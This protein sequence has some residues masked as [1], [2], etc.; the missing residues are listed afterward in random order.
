MYYHRADR[1][2]FLGYLVEKFPACFFEDPAQRRP[3]K[4]DI[5]I[6][7]EKQN[8]LDH[9][10]LSQTLDWYVNHFAYRYSLKAG[11]ERVDLDGKKAGTVTPAEQREALEWIAARK[12]ELNERQETQQA[13]VVKIVARNRDLTAPQQWP[14][15]K[16]TREGC[17]EI[18]Q[19]PIVSPAA[20]NATT[21]GHANGAI[22]P[23]LPP[24]LTEMQS[25]LAIA[26]S[27]L[28]EKQYELLRPVLA[29]A[30]LREI[31]SRAEKLIGSLTTD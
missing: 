29:A 28:T 15:V 7:L 30:A 5:I 17:Q 6:D 27:I 8:V 22:A 31:V 21:N 4:H 10:K 2:E 23:S 12:R 24:G 1:D 16:I 11:T 19:A 3:L 14:V 13:A 20:V 9:D 26:S 25:A 18:Q